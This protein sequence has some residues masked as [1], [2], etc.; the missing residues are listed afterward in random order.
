MTECR[1]CSMHNL[2]D[3]HTYAHLAAIPNPVIFLAQAVSGKMHALALFIRHNNA[4][5]RN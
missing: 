1:V 2:I 5:T 4:V 3:G